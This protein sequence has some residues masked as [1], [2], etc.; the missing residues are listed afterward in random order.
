[1]RRCDETEI[2]KER[3]KRSRK[4]RK[5]KKKKRRQGKAMARERDGLLVRGVSRDEGDHTT[6]AAITSQSNK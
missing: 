2:G 1:M 5:E 4:I 6:W 3:K